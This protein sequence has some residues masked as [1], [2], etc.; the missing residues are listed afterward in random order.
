M[1]KQTKGRFGN[2]A[3]ARQSANHKVKYERQ[4]VRTEKNKLKRRK[5]HIEHHPN[6]LQVTA[7]L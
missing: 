3:K 6:D 2:K 5:K 7:N 1:A 4:R